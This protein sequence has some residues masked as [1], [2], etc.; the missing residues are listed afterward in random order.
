MESDV[1]NEQAHTI[2]A[3]SPSAMAWNILWRSAG[4]IIVLG[5]VAAAIYGALVILVFGV[6]SGDLGEALSTLPAAALVGTILG[7]GL[8]LPIGV[9]DGLVL[10]ILTRLRH[11][12]LSDPQLYQ[13]SAGVVSSVV[14]GAG[15]FVGFLLLLPVSEF[16]SFLIVTVLPSIVS[17][18]IGYWVGRR[19]AK[20]YIKASGHDAL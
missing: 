16:T 1:P 19:V 10:V 5:A 15:A 8:A 18:F 6:S 3:I 4:F 20:W 17:A 2:G 14:C 7:G 11:Y 13:R 9:T 12:P